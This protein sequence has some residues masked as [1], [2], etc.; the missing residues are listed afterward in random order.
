MVA[1]RKL[2]SLLC[3]LGAQ[4]QGVDELLDGI[5]ALMREQAW[6]PGLPRASIV[7]AAGIVASS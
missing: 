1:E 4:D 5:C 2:F 6:L 7:S 3:R